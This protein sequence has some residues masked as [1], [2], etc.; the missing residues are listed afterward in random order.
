MSI[1]HYIILGVIALVPLVGSAQSAE[2]LRQQISAQQRQLEQINK[3]IELYEKELVQVGARKQTLQNAVNELDV[4]LKKTTAQIK[5]TQNRIATTELEIKELDGDI[6]QKEELIAIDSAAIGEMVRQLHSMDEASFVEHLLS[7]DSLSGVWDE[8]ETIMTLQQTMHDHMVSLLNIK[9]DL[10]RDLS[11]VRKKREELE[12]QRRTLA[13]E[14]RSVSVTKQEQSN[15]LSQTRS[16]ESNYQKLLA[17]K[18]AAKEQFENALDD[19]ESRLQYTLD[20]TH[21]PPAGK[22]VLRWPLDQITITQ[23]FGVTA[24]SRRLYASGSHNGV[25]FR[26]AVGTPVKAALSGTVQATGDSD[27][28]RGCY[29]YGKWVLIRHGNGLS[30]LYAHFSDIAVSQ[31]QS[32][33]TGQVIGYAGATGYATGPHLHFTVYASDAV[34]VRQLGTNTPCGKAVIPVSPQSGYLN[35]LDYL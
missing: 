2:Q 17:D 30:T 1:R 11:A 28:I 24:D 29:S 31:G 5:A 19:L 26:A 18:R 22:G 4:T 14:E 9:E 16:Q 35:P 32:V 23:Q 13:A 7:E 10:T 15:L 34:Q 8:T 3:E 6:V 12:Q 27:S 21:I 33:S 20:P 25:D